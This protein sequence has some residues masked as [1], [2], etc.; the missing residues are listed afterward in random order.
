MNIGYYSTS[1]VTPPQYYACNYRTVWASGCNKITVVFLFQE[2]AT[3]KIWAVLKHF[4]NSCQFA[5]VTYLFKNSRTKSIYIC[6]PW[7]YFDSHFRT[8]QAKSSVESSLKP[9]FQYASNENYA[10]VLF[11][12]SFKLHFDYW[13][14]WIKNGLHHIGYN[15]VTCGRCSSVFLHK[16]RNVRLLR[17]WVTHKWS[18]CT[19]ISADH[20]P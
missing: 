17:E 11:P 3:V 15:V 16:I 1:A 6:R 9:S 2:A 10:D 19:V 14:L 5:W 12:S 7:K 20:W 8:V 4:E 18:N 13:S